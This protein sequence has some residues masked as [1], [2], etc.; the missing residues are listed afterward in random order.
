ML[1]CKQ[2][3][4]HHIRGIRSGQLCHHRGVPN[5]QQEENSF[6][7]STHFHEGNGQIGHDRQCFLSFQIHRNAHRLLCSVSSPLVPQRR[8]SRPYLRSRL[9]SRRRRRCRERRR[10]HGGCTVRSDAVA[11]DEGDI[12]EGEARGQNGARLSAD[13]AIWSALD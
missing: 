13:G 1:R 6:R 12:C 4:V 10:Q 5:R 8:Q 7:N 2:A 3:A 9:G 11:R